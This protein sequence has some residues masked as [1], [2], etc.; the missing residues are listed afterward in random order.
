MV[1]ESTA[2]TRQLISAKGARR[3]AYFRL[4][5]PASLTLDFRLSLF[6]RLPAPVVKKPLRSGQAADQFQTPEVIT[7]W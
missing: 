7:L 5:S 2:N 4:F 1:L 6:I 3:P